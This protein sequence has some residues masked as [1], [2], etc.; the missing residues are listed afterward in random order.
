MPTDLVR[1]PWTAA[2]TASVAFFGSNNVAQAATART[3]SLSGNGWVAL[4]IIAFLVWAIYMLIRGAM[5]LEHRD[6]SLGRRRRTDDGWFGIFPAG[7]PDD[8]DSPDYQH[9]D[10]GGEGGEGG[11]AG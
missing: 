7:S 1:N 10:D 2:A 3:P 9:H 11:E 4:G 8:E 6:A 5:H